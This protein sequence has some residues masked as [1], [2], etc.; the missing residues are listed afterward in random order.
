MFMKWRRKNTLGT[1]LCH[2]ETYPWKNIIRVTKT[3]NNAINVTIELGA[4][5]H[6]KRNI[7]ES[8]L[9][10]PHEDTTTHHLMLARR[11]SSFPLCACTSPLH[12]FR[13]L[14]GW[15]QDR[16][17]Y[18]ISG[19]TIVRQHLDSPN[20]FQPL[21]LAHLQSW[22]FWCCGT[23]TPVLA[24]WS[25]GSSHHDK[26]A[27]QVRLLSFDASA[28]SK[29]Q[30]EVLLALPQLYCW[31]CLP[32]YRKASLM[33]ASNKAWNNCWTL[34]IS[35]PWFTNPS[36]VCL[37]NPATPSGVDWPQRNSMF[38]PWS[39]AFAV[40]SWIEKKSSFGIVYT[41]HR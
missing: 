39:H 14:L 2:L 17:H 32:Q 6:S 18:H 9:W 12:V 20:R 35:F 8:I 27:G 31:L 11:S 36:A 40:Q 4:N 37:S 5:K 1:I 3:I 13:W 26:S 21:A 30:Q 28:L 41:A 23:C 38:Q 16:C 25:R 22:R 19:H 7:M 15:C 24:S 33:S 34:G 10:Y 29:A